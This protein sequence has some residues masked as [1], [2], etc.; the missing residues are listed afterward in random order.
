MVELTSK[1]NV[2]DERI[3]ALSQRIAEAMARL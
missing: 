2:V 1:G 3:P